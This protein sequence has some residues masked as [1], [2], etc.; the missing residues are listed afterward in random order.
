V[1]S[2]GSGVKSTLRNYIQ[3]ILLLALAGVII[4]L[5]GYVTS[6]IPDTSLSP[7][8]GT[9]PSVYTEQLF[10]ANWE[11]FADQTAFSNLGYTV[12]IDNNYQYIEIIT[13]SS[14]VG[15]V[16]GLGYDDGVQCVYIT[17]SQYNETV[18]YGVFPTG[19]SFRRICVSVSDHT[20][21][22]IY[23]IKADKNA[24]PQDAV[25]SFFT[26]LENPTSGSPASL[27]GKTIINI[28]G[29]CSGIALILTA[30]RKMDIWI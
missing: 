11:L 12:T 18:V 24:S 22:T 21:I 4:S 7:S 16:T 9:T 8:G 27:S 19:V 28:V 10:K 29:W 25:R 23:L 6:T 15:V 20:L 26:S 13:S 30:L 2:S 5:V 3:G 1:L 17:K 14:G